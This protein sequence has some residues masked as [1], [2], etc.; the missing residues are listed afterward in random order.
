VRVDAYLAAAG[1]ALGRGWSQQV[2]YAE[3]NAGAKAE[4]AMGNVSTEVAEAIEA[5]WRDYR[6]G[7]R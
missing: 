5:A 2:E 6:A 7:A 3:L 4:G 1:D